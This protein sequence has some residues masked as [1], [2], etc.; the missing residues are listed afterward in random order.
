MVEGA[1]IRRV[2][3]AK[4]EARGVGDN[5]QTEQALRGVSLRCFVTEQDI[6][7]MALYVCSP[8]GA[9]ITGQA[10]SIDGGLEG[11]N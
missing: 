11:L 2:L 9:T 6:A 1:R 3:R 4:A 10:L 8:F 5:E 7:N